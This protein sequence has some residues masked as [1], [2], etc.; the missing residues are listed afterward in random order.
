MQ[1]LP[2]R[3]P[4]ATIETAEGISMSVIRDPV[5]DLPYAI[6]TAHLSRVAED[7]SE[8]YAPSPYGGLLDLS[9]VIST[10]TETALTK[11]TPTRVHVA[12]IHHEHDTDIRV[13]TTQLAVKRQVSV[14][15]RDRWGEA[16]AADQN[17]P[18][19][20]RYGL[21]EDYESLDNDKAEELFFE[22]MSH[23][24]SCHYVDYNVIEV[25]G[26]TGAGHQVRDGRFRAYPATA[27]PSDVPEETDFRSAHD[28][29]EEAIAACEA[30]R[31]EHQDAAVVD[32]VGRRFWRASH[33]WS[34]QEMPALA[35]SPDPKVTTFH[36]DVWE[37]T[38]D[39]DKL[40]DHLEH[41][42]EMVRN[43]Y[44]EGAVPG[45]WGGASWARKSSP[46]KNVSAAIANSTAMAAAAARPALSPNTNKTTS[47]AG[48]G[49]LTTIP[50]TGGHF[51]PPAGMSPTRACCRI[52]HAIL[53]GLDNGLIDKSQATER[54]RRRLG[55]DGFAAKS[56]SST[57]RATASAGRA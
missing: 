16:Y 18:R 29:L 15:V 37:N 44:R 49:I 50:N 35:R 27:W 57:A 12:S 14:Y 33:D 7:R 47:A 55:L 39:E 1:L 30:A 13:G 46:T 21:P 34:V 17:I 43:G 9:A 4:L 25:P 51:V 2:K 53:V 45:G 8:R 10:K 3:S 26:W 36:V 22:A 56:P 5:A 32:H 52:Q 11:H 6:A 40:A 23:F 48:N 42:A 31:S 24:D 19:K 28:A 41:L 54:L 38:V 20:E